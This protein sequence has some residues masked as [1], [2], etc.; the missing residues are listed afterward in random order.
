METVEYAP[1]RLADVFGEAGQPTVLLW[2]GMQ[3]DAR[4]A[5]GPLAR[6]VADR[7]AAVV[8]PDWNS[9]ADD[10][11]RADLLASL[12][13]TR[14]RADRLV[15]VGW[16]MGGAAAAGVALDAGHYGVD[17]V[18]TVCLAGAFMIPD[19]CSGRPLTDMLA[20]ARVGSPF[21]LLHGVA[22]DAV[23]VSASRDFAAD[24]KRV[25]WPVELI[26]LAADHGSIAGADYD[27]AADRYVPGTSE[28][29]RRVAA[30]VAARIAGTLRYE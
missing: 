10:G 29:A 16:S 6:L 26:E 3:T 14:E 11:G 18:H 17:L 20:C 4:A 25:G 19:P 5:V 1:G 13:F 27:A 7:G 8:A 30:E 24:L 22:D 28:E 23:P 9:H 12:E 15:L 21:T 2:H